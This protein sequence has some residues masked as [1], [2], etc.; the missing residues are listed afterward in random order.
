M[1][2]SSDI[3]ALVRHPAVRVEFRRAAGPGGQNVNK[4]ETAVRLSFD[5]ARAGL[6]PDVA[7]R[8][9]RLAGHRVVRGG[10]LVIDAQ[11]FRTQER[12]RE[13]AAR[14]LAAL[15]DAAQQVPKTRRPSR[16]SKAAGVRRLEAKR[17]RAAVKAARARLRDA[18]P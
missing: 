4:V 7:A 8:L 10:V 15:L 11:R 1:A 5:V 14:R 17:S 9:V 2:A 6:S 16:P 12:N 18:E 3:D 13:D